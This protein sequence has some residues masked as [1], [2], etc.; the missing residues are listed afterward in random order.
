[1][2]ASSSSSSSRSQQRKLTKTLQSTTAIEADTRTDSGLVAATATTAEAAAAAGKPHYCNAPKAGRY[3]TAKGGSSQ[4]TA[5]NQPGRPKEPTTLKQAA[6]LDQTMARNEA[7][8]VENVRTRQPPPGTSNVSGV[9]EHTASRQLL[10]YSLLVEALATLVATTKRT[11][12]LHA[13]I[14]LF[15]RIIQQLG[16]IHYQD[17]QSGRCRQQDAYILTGAIDL[18]VGKLTVTNPA[19]ASHAAMASTSTRAAVAPLGPLQVSGSTV[20]TAVQ[21]VTGATRP[22]IRAAYRSAGDLGDVAASLFVHPQQQRRFFVKKEVASAALASSSLSGLTILQVHQLLQRIATVPQGTGSQKE[23]HALLVKL[24]RGA[25]SKDE[26]RFLVRTLLGNMRIGATIK[27]I[28]SALATAIEGPMDADQTTTTTTTTGVVITA[29]NHE[30][31]Q[32][33]QQIY[34]ICPR[35]DHIVAALLCGGI[36]FAEQHCS[37]QVGL[38]IQPMLANPAHSLDDVDKF[39]KVEKG[40]SDCYWEAVAEWKYDGV[41]C[42]AHCNRTTVKL[43]SRHLLENTDQYPDAVSYLLAAK[44]S[45]VD[46]F[47]LDAEI[48]GVEPNTDCRDGFRLLPFQELSSRRGAIKQAAT[49]SNSLIQIRIYAFDL[50]Y[51]NGASLLNVPLWK[52][53]EMLRNSF[54]VTDGLGLATSVSLQRFDESQLQRTLKEAVADGAEGLMLKLTGQ[55]SIPVLSSAKAIERSFGYESGTRSQ[56][57]L[58]LKRD[59]V[60]GFA[61]TIDVVPIGA[62]YGN[63]RKAQK[64]FLSPILLAVYDEEEGAFRSIARCMSFS[65]AMYDAMRDFYF[66]GKP[67]PAGVGL[68]TESTAVKNVTAELQSEEENDTDDSLSN[69][70]G[71]VSGD[72]EETIVN[73][74]TTNFESLNDA[75]EEKSTLLN[76]V[77]CLGSPPS[78]SW[79]ITNDPPVIWFQPKE[80]FEVSFA[81]L[82][83]SRAHTAA[84]GWVDNASGRGVALRFPRFKRRRPDKTIEQA[85]TCAQIA[86]M[87]HSQ[88][89][90]QSKN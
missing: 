79:I 3:D 1:M 86:Q 84:A 77:N 60:Q 55:S 14:H 9:T 70:E 46:S 20:S 17:E 78:S 50:L 24:L 36:D 2:V 52:R 5:V 89:K 19:M 53:Q 18:L 31:T 12:K 74:T 41:R 66:Y 85:T 40:D 75:Q 13:L 64:G 33:L 23:R 27:T 44:R 67:Y 7:V 57:W 58:K 34:N 69:A 6:C 65:D 80:V 38:P 48:V 63:G 35:L 54:D 45:T 88:T 43:W 28:L 51:L 61:D 22:Q 30:A 71:S 16:G 72:E 81:D 11:I 83:L 87:F 29:T 59:Y 76:R 73:P 62:W 82:T 4:V 21:T 42:Q 26:M 37:V 56:L 15:H 68:V 8:S 47:I 32:R 39:M 49:S 25:Q 90:V 10:P